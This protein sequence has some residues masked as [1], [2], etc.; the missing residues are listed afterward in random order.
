MGPRGAS[1][2]PA[3]P[4]E[5][6]PS[7]FFSCSTRIRSGL[8]VVLGLWR[9]PFLRQRIHFTPFFVKSRGFQSSAANLCSSSSAGPFLFSSAS[10]PGTE[11][12]PLQ[13]F[14]EGVS[15]P[16]PLYICRRP[17]VGSDILEDLVARLLVLLSRIMY[18]RPAGLNKSVT[19][20]LHARDLL[21]GSV[22]LR[23][24]AAFFGRVH[25]QR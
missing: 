25:P 10:R 15:L 3:P 6:P 19:W 21:H 8:S 4:E 11:M 16:F 1:N 7:R 14:P 12:T 9:D 17:A 23:C 24:L 5:H 20:M 22:S 2:D 18:L 13:T